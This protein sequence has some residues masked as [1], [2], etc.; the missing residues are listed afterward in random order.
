MSKHALRATLAAFRWTVVTQQQANAVFA[1]MQ[2]LGM[3]R[4]RA[5]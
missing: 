4:E 5:K 2:S 3:L 1:T